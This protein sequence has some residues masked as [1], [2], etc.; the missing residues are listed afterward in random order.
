M[1]DITKPIVTDIFVLND[2]FVPKKLNNYLT[3]GTFNIWGVDSESE[4]SLLEERLPYII[5]T[6]LQYN[7]DIWCLQ[8]VSKKVLEKLENS[9]LTQIYAFSHKSLSIDWTDVGGMC[10]IILTKLSPKKVFTIKIIDKI[11][12]TVIGII[13]AD[14]LVINVHLPKHNSKD[15][16][17][18]VK[19]VMTTM[20]DV[21]HGQLINDVVMVGDFNTHLDSIEQ[22]F[23]YDSKLKD[24][25]RILELDEAGLT[26]NTNSNMMLWNIKK[27]IKKYRYSGVLYKGGRLY[28]M[29]IRII[30]DKPFKHKNEINNSKLWWMSKHFGVISKFSI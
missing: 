6:I 8:E 4:L 7:M 5:D 26:E 3:V 1:S 21:T 11:V 2:D 25:W 22:T 16:N 12:Y 15:M 14:I 30:G 28:P 18:I 27:K 19:N 24:M 10:N 20:N 17:I 9:K 29:N 23:I 13:V